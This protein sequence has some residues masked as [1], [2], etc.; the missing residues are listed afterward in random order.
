M[1]LNIYKNWSDDA[2]VEGLASTKQFTN[3]EKVLKK[4]KGLIDQVGL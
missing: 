1:T 3:M 2:C 4:N